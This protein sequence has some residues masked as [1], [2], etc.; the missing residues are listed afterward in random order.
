MVNALGKLKDLYQNTL[1]IIIE[2]T[3]GPILQIQGKFLE[4]LR[5]RLSIAE[6]V[7]EKVK[8][9]RKGREFMGL[10]PFHHEKTPS[11]TVNEEKEFYHCFG[12]GAHGDAIGFLME[13]QKY[14]FM[15]A[16]KELASRV[17]LSLPEETS[18]KGGTS[19]E[20]LT[21]LRQVLQEASAW[22]HNNLFLARYSESLRYAER[23]SLKTETLKKFNIGFAPEGSSPLEKYLKTK[24]FSDEILLAAGLLAQGETTRP[25]Y[26]R[27]RKRLMFPIQDAQGR[28]VAFGGRLLDKGEPKY[29]NSPETPLFSKGKLLYGYYQAKEKANTEPLIVVEGY[30][31]VISLHQ[32]GFK[33]AVAPLGTALTEDQIV[34]AWRLSPEPILCFDG[35][36]AGLKAAA[37]AAERVLPLLKPGYSLRFAI[38]PQGEDPDSL[39][40]KGDRF[41]MV[42]NQAHSLVDA[43]WLFLTHGKNFKTPEQKAALQKQC[44][45]WTQGIQDGEI[46]KHYHYAFKDLFYKNI[47]GK[48]ANIQSLSPLRKTNLNLSSIY[49]HLLLAI[50]INHPILLDEASDDLASLEFKEPKL[51]DLRNGIL[52]FYAAGP[53]DEMNLKDY[54]LKQGFEKELDDIFSSRVL[55]HGAFASPSS[56][57]EGA[58]EGWKEIFNRIQHGLG[59]K[60]LQ[61]AQE[62]LAEEMSEEA[63]HRLKALKK[64]TL[65]QY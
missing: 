29:L 63:W 9:T 59:K 53:L 17:G 50:L 14:S 38:L 30:M 54:L 57:F 43:L 39:V 2:P 40:Q 20:D 19:Q 6:V 22:F 61:E 52:H 1:L 32:A 42:L 65:L 44:A 34:L 5:A 55:I 16:V 56:S 35:D 7:G 36:G 3:E 13:A 45:L 8:L 25:P 41:Q 26:E 27:F 60:D 51:H 21:P 37:R 18:E 4:T 62:H 58:R 48:K 11:F 46:K 28:V 31:D 15:E 24:G 33:G 64:T 12:C 23:R 47:V 49:E 10:C